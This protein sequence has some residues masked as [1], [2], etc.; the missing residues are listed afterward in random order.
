MPYISKITLPQEL[1]QR[2]IILRRRLAVF[3]GKGR[4]KD[5]LMDQRTINSV[6]LQYSFE[7]SDTHGRKRG[8]Y[9]KCYTLNK[10]QCS[11]RK[12]FDPSTAGKIAQSCL[13]SFLAFAPCLYQRCAC[14]S[15]LRAKM[16]PRSRPRWWK[17]RSIHGS[18]T[19]Y[20]KL[21]AE[22]GLSVQLLIKNVYIYFSRPL[23]V[24]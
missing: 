22:V 7:L 2:R 23:F 10:K 16:F 3:L 18:S 4:K 12:P 17:W 21:G 11:S 1:S 24:Q 20:A 13:R 6:A 19:R 8:R 15:C 14:H 9:S 5:S